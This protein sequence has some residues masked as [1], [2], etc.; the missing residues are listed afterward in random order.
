MVKKLIVMIPA[1]IGSKGIPQKVIR[2]FNGQPLIFSAINVALKI[3]NAY[4]F[5]NTDSKKI[6]SIVKKKYADSVSIYFRPDDLGQDEVTLDFLALNFVEKN[7]FTD[8]MLVT[9]QPTSPLLRPETLIKLLDVF[10]N[11]ELSTVLTVVENKKL[12]WKLAADGHFIKQYKSRLNRQQLAATYT[13]TGAAVI[14][15]TSVLLKNK[16]RFGDRVICIPVSKEES[17]DIDNYSDW[18]LAQELAYGRKILFMTLA[19]KKVGSGHLLRTI[20]LANYFPDYL[21]EFILLDT[22]EEWLNYVSELNYNLTSV[23][24]KSKGFELAVTRNPSLVILDI[25]NTSEDEIAL[26]KDISST[27]KVISFEDLGAGSLKTDLTINELY[28][29]INDACDNILSGPSFCVFRDG[30]LDLKPVPKPLRKNDVLISFGG[31]D[32]NDLT[33]RVLRILEGCKQS[34]NIRVIIGIGAIR[35]IEEVRKFA[36]DSHHFIDFSDVNGEIADEW[37]NAKLGI[38]GGGRTVYELA[39]CKTQTIVLCQNSRELTHLYSSKINGIDNLGL[40]SEAS[41]SDIHD[42]IMSVDFFSETSLQPTIVSINPNQTNKNVIKAIRD[43]LG[44]NNV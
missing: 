42:A 7:N 41:D 28:P 6:E 16:S 13:E 22:D 19:N 32:P 20:S 11:D 12:E 38:C 1:R 37:M 9:I 29:P 25:L 8:D 5:V 4:V 10:Q 2:P 30:F 39:V 35:L 40:H 23:S 24:S 15:N 17:I 34:F 14:C 36:S 26:L 44:E 33:L 18:L 21:I 43:T 3:P 31:T 27:V